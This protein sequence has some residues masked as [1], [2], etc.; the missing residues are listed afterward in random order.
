MSFFLIVSGLSIKNS[1]DYFNYLKTVL[2]LLLFRRPCPVK[3]RSMVCL[4][5]RSGSEGGTVYFVH[6]YEFFFFFSGSCRLGKTRYFYVFW[7]YL[8]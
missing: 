4:L 2:T 5:V 8:I 6:L 3:M 1:L 7:M